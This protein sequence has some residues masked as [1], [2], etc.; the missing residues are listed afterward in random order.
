MLQTQTVWPDLKDS[1]II[2]IY[3]TED[4]ITDCEH[5]MHHKHTGIERDGGQPFCQCPGLFGYGGLP[6]TRPPRSVGLKTKK[7]TQ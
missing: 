1:L 3:L 6:A 7:H 5:V 2:I 4:E